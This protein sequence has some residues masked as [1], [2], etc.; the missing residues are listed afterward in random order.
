[1]HME[2]KLNKYLLMDCFCAYGSH[3]PGGLR[4]PPGKKHASICAV[5]CPFLIFS[6]DVIIV[7]EGQAQE[8]GFS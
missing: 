3:C 8:Q 2:E 4:V 6:T 1:M 7:T 5:L